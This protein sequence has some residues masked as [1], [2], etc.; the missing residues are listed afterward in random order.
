VIARFQVSYKPLFLLVALTLV[1]SGALFG[2]GVL[3]VTLLAITGNA[4]LRGFSIAV[5]NLFSIVAVTFFLLLSLWRIVDYVGAMKA[6]LS[7]EP[8]TRRQILKLVGYTTASLIQM[9][10]LLIILLAIRY[11]G[12][13]VTDS[14]AR[15]G[16]YG[17]TVSDPGHHF[18]CELLYLCS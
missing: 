5:F 10:S 1:V 7:E 11:I 18:V 3:A 2:I 13:E 8:L 15:Y 9:L 17:L 16:L 14:I 12:Y 4:T 6:I